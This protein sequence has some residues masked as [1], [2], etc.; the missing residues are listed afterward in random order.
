MHV[1]GL[2]CAP[3]NAG[4]LLATRRHAWTHVR[5][6]CLREAAAEAV[7]IGTGTGTGTGTGAAAPRHVLRQTGAEQARYCA[8]M[9]ELAREAGERARA[10]G[11]KLE[12][13]AAENAHVLD[14]YVSAE[15]ATREY[16]C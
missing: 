12:A 8:E 4:H 7:V 14:A 11:L 3:G 10:A 16:E 2:F 1:H 13:L 9:L 15:I 6:W 5:A